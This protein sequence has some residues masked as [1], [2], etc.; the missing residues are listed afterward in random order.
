MQEDMKFQEGNAK[1]KGT[2]YGFYSTLEYRREDG[3]REY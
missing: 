2:R 1:N 3:P